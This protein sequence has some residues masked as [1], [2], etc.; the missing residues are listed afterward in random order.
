LPPASLITVAI[1]H[2]VAVTVT[3]TI[4]LVAVNRLAPLLPS[5]LP[6]KPSLSSSHSTLVA[7]AIAR[8]IPL[9][10]FVTRHPYPHSHHLATL[11][12][13]S[14]MLLPLV[15]CFIFTFNVGWAVSQQVSQ[16][17]MI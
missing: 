10:L 11:T 4:A 7:N 17:A 3:V 15:D 13:F 14:H 16:H 12:L 6:P 5:L 8:F 2:V 9:A 1:T